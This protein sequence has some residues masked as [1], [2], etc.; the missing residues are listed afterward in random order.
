MYRNKFGIQTQ[1]D[2]GFRFGSGCHPRPRSNKE[3]FFGGMSGLNIDFLYLLPSHL[4]GLK[5]LKA[6]WHRKP[7][8]ELALFIHGKVPHGREAQ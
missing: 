2:F 4:P 1:I 7:H 8:G 3:F 6:H 5:S